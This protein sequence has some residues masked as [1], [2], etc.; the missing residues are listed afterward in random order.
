MVDPVIVDVSI[1][2]A[3]KH[4]RGPCCGSNGPLVPSRRT[5]V[6]SIALM[7]IAALPTWE[8]DK[9]STPNIIVIDGWIL[10]DTDL[11]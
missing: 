5:L 1:A 6:R 8:A 2:D 7:T 3:I 9:R 10:L 11:H 4:P